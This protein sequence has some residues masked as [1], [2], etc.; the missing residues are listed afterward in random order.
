MK[1]P[2]GEEK[3]ARR[4]SPSPRGRH[5][6]EG[7]GF[8]GRRSSGV[9]RRRSA[10]L[11]VKHRRCGARSAPD[12]RW[13]GS[14]PRLTV[15]HRKCGARRAPDRR[16]RGSAPRRTVKHRR[17]GARSAPDRR[18]RGSAPRRT[19]KHRRCGARRAPD[20]RWRGSGPRLTV[21]HRRCGVRRA[22]DRRWRGSAP[23]LTVKH[24]RCG[25][26][27]RRIGVGVVHQHAVRLDERGARGRLPG[28]KRRVAGGVIGCGWGGHG[29]PREQEVRPIEWQKTCI[30]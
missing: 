6:G 1:D 14:A 4:Q 22:P 28:P 16:W 11:T 9:R 20:R 23:R 19:V 29:G 15:K 5:Q 13:R 2:L 30:L 18:W 7:G 8:P 27:R 26:R 21:K 3:K 24:R 17:C 25:A 12:R 10:R